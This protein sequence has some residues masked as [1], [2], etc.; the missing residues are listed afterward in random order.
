MKNLT[1]AIEAQQTKRL[2]DFSDIINQATSIS[3]LN[4]YQF[5][6]LLPKGKTL[7]SFKDIEDAK[8]YFLKRKEKQTNKATEN[9]LNTIMSIFNAGE[10]L[11][12]TIQIEWKKSATWG[13]N[14]N[15][16]CKFHYVNK[17]GDVRCG[18]VKSES[19][20]GC[21]YDKQ[22]TAVARCLNQIKE[23][24][25]PLYIAKDKAIEKSNHEVFG[26]GSGYGICPS[27]EGGIGVSCYPD[28][29][30]KIGYNFQAIA[31]GKNFDIFIIT[32]IN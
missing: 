29:F 1:L 22:S 21:G 17:E 26:Y 24:L 3:D 16:E 19:I 5:L 8:A 28:I 30:S 31:S 2:S 18:F 9:E 20:G 32:K 10:L 7:S 6:D 23:V 11:N 13:S 4:K 14:P 25:K 27:I 12:A 15:A